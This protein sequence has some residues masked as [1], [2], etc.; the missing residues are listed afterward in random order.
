MPE[1]L[2]EWVS[3]VPCRNA[4]WKPV[5]HPLY[6]WDN[7]YGKH[8]EK[9]KHSSATK[10][11][12]I[13]WWVLKFVEA[14]GYETE[15]YWTEEGW[16]LAKFSKSDIDTAQ[17]CWWILL[18]VWWPK[19]FLMPW[20]WPVEVNYLEVKRIATGKQPAKV[21][22]SDCQAE[23][24]WYRLLEYCQEVP[25]RNRMEAKLPEILIWT[26]WFTLPGR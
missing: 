20:N 4:T 22:L 19:K 18:G 16:K 26:L 2:P 6:G 3:P 1:L 25:G 23:A 9:L 21:K 11:P 8:V 15:A 14:G 13:E 17:N 7:E 10:Y 12:D 24:E 5:S